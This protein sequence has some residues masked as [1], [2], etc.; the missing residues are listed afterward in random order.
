MPYI[1]L[2]LA[3]VINAL[4]SILLKVDAASAPLSLDRGVGALILE[5]KL[6]IAGLAAFGINVILY[7]LALKSLPLT[8]AYPVMV[9]GSFVIVLGY[10]AL[11]LHEGVSIW[12]LAG[13]VLIFTGILL[14][15]LK[16]S[17]A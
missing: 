4:A 1:Y 9:G 8:V 10:A 3:F 15:L 12:Q 7:W 2:F 5:H 11:A 13:Y 17:Q 6:L 16:G 14:V